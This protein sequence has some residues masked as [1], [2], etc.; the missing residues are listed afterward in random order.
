MVLLQDGRFLERIDPKLFMLNSILMVIELVTLLLTTVSII[1]RHE[2]DLHMVVA[3]EIFGY[4][5]L[6][7]L[8]LV[9]MVPLS[10]SVLILLNSLPMI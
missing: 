8:D 1:L 10:I 4:K 6:P 5:L 2:Q 9:P 7:L 3:P